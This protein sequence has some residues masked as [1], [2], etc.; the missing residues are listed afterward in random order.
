[1]NL[2]IL[3]EGRLRNIPVTLFQNMST[4]LAGEVALSFFP[5]YSSGGHFVQQSGTV[6]VIF[7]LNLVSIIFLCP[8]QRRS[9]KKP[10]QSLKG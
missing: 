1:M 4:G 8:L 9:L 2:T 3:V 10:V 7:F 6:T 5:I